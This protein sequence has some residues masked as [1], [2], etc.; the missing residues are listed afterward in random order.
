MDEILNKINWRLLAHQKLAL[1]TTI[2]RAEHDDH[3]LALIPAEAQ[4]DLSGIVHLIDWL[5]D[6][7]AEYGQ[8]VVWLTEDSGTLETHQPKGLT[9]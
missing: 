6:L 1:L 3:D 2:D 8:P 5:Q 9:P 7:G 4:S